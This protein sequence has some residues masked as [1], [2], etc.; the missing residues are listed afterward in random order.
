MLSNDVIELIKNSKINE[1]FNYDAEYKFI[2]R[3]GDNLVGLVFYDLQETKGKEYPRFIH[4]IIHPKYK[5]NRLAYK[6]L[7]ES[8]K[9]LVEEGH[10]QI[11]AQIDNDKTL[12]IQ[13]ATKFGY[14]RYANRNGYGFYYKTLGG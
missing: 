1:E 11:V 5:R 7:K 10:K 13:L 14:K 6:M 4:V 9:V 8:E 12:M 3:D 2:Q